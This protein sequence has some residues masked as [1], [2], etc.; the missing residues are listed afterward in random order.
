MTYYLVAIE[1]RGGAWGN[2]S[3]ADNQQEF[4]E[5][6]ALARFY[7]VSDNNIRYI[8]ATAK[9]VTRQEFFEEMIFSPVL[10]HVGKKDIHP[11]DLIDCL[12][13]IDFDG[14]DIKELEQ[15][16]GKLK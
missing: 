7:S 12:K 15:A 5:L 11:V 10:G 3:E 16:L 9:K 2:Y 8:F 1:Q 14:P 6:F 13:L 4:K